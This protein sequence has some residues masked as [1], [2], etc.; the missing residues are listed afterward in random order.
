[1]NCQVQ[2]VLVCLTLHSCDRYHAVVRRK[3]LVGIQ[4]QLFLVLVR[5]A[6]L[7]EVCHWNSA[8]LSPLTVTSWLSINCESVMCV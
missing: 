6:L 2:F 4:C 1:M 7:G 3:T 5:R 8:L